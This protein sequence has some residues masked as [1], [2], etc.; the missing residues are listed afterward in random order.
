MS[1]KFK[2]MMETGESF[3]KIF[4][5]GVPEMI[6]NAVL[7]SLIPIIDS[8]IVARL[9][10]TTYGALGMTNNFLHSLL[11]LAEA[12]PV[13][14]IAIIG[15]HNGA[16]KYEECGKDL[17]DAFWTTTLLGL[18]QFILIFFSAANIFRWLGV[19]EDMVYQGAPFLQVKSLG[20]LLVFTSLGFFAFLRGLKNTR[21]PMIIYII[22]LIIFLFFDWTL[23]LGKF[24]FEPMGLMGSAIA[25]IIQ[26][27]TMLTI[28]V[29]YILT[30]K[31][32]KPYFS[33]AFFGIFRKE[34]ILNL[35]NLSWPIMIDKT[36]IAMSYIWLSKMIAPMGTAAIA[37][38]DVI[39]NLERFAFLPAV[40][41]SQII[42]FLVSNRLGAND[43]EGAK[44][45]IKKVM[46]LTLIMLTG[47]LSFLCF[48][49][50]YLVSFFDPNNEFT[51][52]AAPALIAISL[53]VVFDFVQLNLAGALR[54]A[55]DVKTVMWARFFCC[56]F[57]FAP[58]AYFISNMNIEN[59]S[60]KFALIYGT[61]YINTGLIG[62]IY[63]KRIRTPKWQQ[64][65]IS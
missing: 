20:I 24:G 61:F 58:I 33:K 17:G 23:V 21:T 29:W 43:G 26:Y 50:E 46:I 9:G 51:N 30:N 44:S 36:S 1:G 13:A 11:K 2:K 45:N 27:S 16:Q 64:K 53:L 55:G 12:I 5:L 3:K 31:K 63:L 37:S 38:Y 56:L 18:V 42:V 15:R 57:F 19:P 32:Y 41:F 34:K 4:S 62:I 49:A 60:L 10:T 47:T 7:V 65:K 52:F 6:S 48:K 25:T 40:G 28:S 35:L 59:Q 22:G 14:A 39:K 54:G 8:Y